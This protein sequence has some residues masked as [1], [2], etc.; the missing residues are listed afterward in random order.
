MQ[1]SDDKDI[2]IAKKIGTNCIEIHT[3]KIANLVKKKINYQK[4]FVSIKNCAKYAQ[5][6]RS[7]GTPLRAQ[8]KNNIYLKKKEREYL[9]TIIFLIEQYYI[10]SYLMY[11]DQ[12]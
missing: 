9:D 12:P 6:T 8:L 7:A 4:E 5:N 10:N 1:Q 11:D 3:G 2:K